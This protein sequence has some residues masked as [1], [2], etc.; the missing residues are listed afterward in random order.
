MK[1][2]SLTSILMGLT[3]FSAVASVVLCWMTISYSRQIRSM[4]P[5]MVGINKSVGAAQ[6]LHG[7]LVEFNKKSPNPSLQAIL[8]SV[9]P[10]ANPAS[11]TA[12]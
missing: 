1:N 5:Q 3:A 8:Q 7:E 10:K 9:E 2:S 4:Q 11:T 12:K 6:L